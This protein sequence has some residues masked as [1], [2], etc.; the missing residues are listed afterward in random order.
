MSK[1]I[2]SKDLHLYYGKKEAL[3]GIDME[4][5]KGEITAMIGPSG[6]GKST[7][8]RSLNRMNDLIPGVTITGSVMYKG[9]DIYSPKTDTVNLRKEIGMV[10][11]Q[12]NPF[13]FSIYENVIYGLK[14]KGE[15]DKNKLDQVVEE[16]LK[17][18]SVWNDV[19]DKLHESA[20]SLSG[21]QQQRVCIARVLAVNPEVILMD[22]PTS[23]LDPVSTGKIENMLL[24]LKENYTIIIVTHN[25]SQASRISDRTAFFLQGELI[26]FDKTKKI[27]L[28]PAKQETEDYISGKFG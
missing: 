25:M 27:F 15:K 10:F 4:I 16:S 17:A 12:P 14:L 22:E 3:K 21:G 23:A 1:I 6:C 18:A 7:Y 5:E 8:L 28:D 26:E 20:L 13:P 2:T 11:Q 9:K 19:K 24:E